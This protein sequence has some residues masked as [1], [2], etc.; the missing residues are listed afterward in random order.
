MVSP[1]TRI[2]LTRF[3][4]QQAQLLGFQFV[5]IAKAE[6][7]TIEGDRLQ[8]WLDLNYC[9]SMSWMK[10]RAEERKDILTYFPDAKSVVCLG[11]NYFFG[12]SEGILKISNYAWGDDYHQVLK[13]KISVLI[14]RIRE[15]FPGINGRVCVDTSPVMEKGW[16][17]R[18]G[19]GWIGKHT[20]LITRNYGSWV[21]LGELILDKELDY[22]LPF[23]EDLCG[24]C[25][26]CMEAC[27]TTAIVDEYILDARKCISYLTIE[28]RETIPKEMVDFLGGWIFGCDIC[29]EVCPWNVKFSQRSSE[30]R[31]APREEI[32]NRDL[33]FWQDLSKENY[34]RTF[35]NS[36]VMR[37]KFFNFKQNIELNHPRK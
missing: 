36:A 11:M 2:D 10:N 18:A 7:L 23:D 35:R 17:Q 31:F 19:I 12:K 37:T 13:E 26:A 30:L 1:Q 16:A 4:K 22:D 27:P 29:Q 34:L 21:F 20:N 9:A 24:N 15:F 3:I 32:K 33:Y 8:T 14:E 25:T 28:H 6:S 5:G